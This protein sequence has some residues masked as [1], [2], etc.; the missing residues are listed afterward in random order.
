[1]IKSQWRGSRRGHILTG[2]WLLALI[3]LV[4]EVMY[5]VS[6]RAATHLASNTSAKYEM[7]SG[8]AMYVPGNRSA[9]KAINATNATN[10]TIALGA[11]IDSAPDYPRFLDAYITEVGRSPAIVMWYQNWVDPQWS[12]F[13]PVRMNTVVDRGAVPMVTWEPWNPP[14]GVNQPQFALRTIVNGD[15][16]AFI[17]SWATAAAAWGKPMFLRFGHEMNGDWYPW[18]VGINGNTPAEYVA[19]WRH[20][21]TIFRQ[22]HADNVSWVWSP[23]AAVP[24]RSMIPLSQF[25]P[26]DAYVN[27]VGLDGYNY[28]STHGSEWRT[29]EQIF[30]ASYHE[31]TT[32]TAKPIMI[33]ET[34]STEEGGDKAAWITNSLM[35]QIPA[36]MP[37]VRAVIWF[38]TNSDATWRIDSSPSALAAFREVAKSYLYSGHVVP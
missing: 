23:N 25:Y 12:P 31:L 6:G 17:R 8:S 13:D 37:K 36:A 35:E 7:S 2:I 19:A 27:W 5:M 30:G 24:G 21:V 16:D 26:G 29:A 10:A 33:A 14:N 9:A 11:Y 32:V 20:I 1:M 38:D 34:A 28:G 3:F 18:G 4:V 22:Q 15:H